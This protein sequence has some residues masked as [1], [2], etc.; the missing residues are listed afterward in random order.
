MRHRIAELSSKSVGTVPSLIVYTVRFIKLRQSIRFKLFRESVG[1]LLVEPVDIGAKQAVP[2]CLFIILV[3]PQRLIDPPHST[4]AVL[5]LKKVE[6]VGRVLIPIVPAGAN[7]LLPVRRRQPTAEPDP[8]G[9]TLNEPSWRRATGIML[10][11]V[12]HLMGDDA[13]ELSGQ[14]ARS[15]ACDKGQRDVDLLVGAAGADAHGVGDAGHVAEHKGHGAGGRRRCAGAGVEQ[16]ADVFVGERGALRGVDGAEEAFGA[17][18]VEVADLQGQ[19]G[20]REGGGG[21]VGCGWDDHDGQCS[22]GV[23]TMMVERNSWNMKRSKLLLVYEFWLSV[24]SKE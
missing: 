18:M 10:K 6:K 1:V 19:G 23:L 11:A 9:N 15:D 17:G 12:D 14:A 22:S 2:K 3:D 7:L 24:G 20:E 5:A 8:V 13:V 16:P 4:S 21:G